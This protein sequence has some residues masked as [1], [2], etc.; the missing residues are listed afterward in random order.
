MLAILRRNKHFFLHLFLLWDRKWGGLDLVINTKCWCKNWNHGAGCGSG[1]SMKKS[2]WVLQKRKHG[3]NGIYSTPW[4]TIYYLDLFFSSFH[5]IR[6]ELFEIEKKKK[7]LMLEL[8]FV[9]NNF[10]F[11]WSYFNKKI[12]EQKTLVFFMYF[13]KFFIE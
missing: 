9:E 1:I 2:L 5:G 13:C 6:L 4:L 8:S 10:F 12:L 3:S 7:K 11:F